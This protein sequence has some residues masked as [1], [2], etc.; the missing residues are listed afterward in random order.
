MMGSKLCSPPRPLAPHVI[1]PNRPNMGA[2]AVP[3][4][5]HVTSYDTND[6]CGLE[7]RTGRCKDSDPHSASWI[8]ICEFDI[9][10]SECGVWSER[11]ISTRGLADEQC[12][13]IVQ[14]SNGTLVCVTRMVRVP[15]QLTRVS[16]TRAYVT[17]PGPAS[18]R[19]LLT[20]TRELG[21][22]RST[23]LTRLTRLA[24]AA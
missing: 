23:P 18:G 4:T 17:F 10:H 8:W 13:Q 3:K 11:S 6:E 19:S 1:R 22:H 24:G 7:R 9:R 5:D 2:Q 16:R 21:Q 14:Y 15:G 12:N 20:L